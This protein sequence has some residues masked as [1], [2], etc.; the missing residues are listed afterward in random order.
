[1]RAASPLPINIKI[2]NMTSCSH[3][4]AVTSIYR[5]DLVPLGRF[6]LAREDVEMRDAAGWTLLH[7]AA[8]CGNAPACRAL[9]GAGASIDAISD[10]GRTALHLVM[11][12]EIAALEVLLDGGANIN[13]VD[14][15]G[16]TPLYDAIRWCDD[17]VVL[18]LINRGADIHRQFPGTGS[19]LHFA[20]EN[21]MPSVCIELLDR[22]IDATLENKDGRTAMDLAIA[23]QKQECIDVMRVWHS[24]NTARR[25]LAEIKMAAI[26]CSADQ[27]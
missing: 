7:A 16:K 26:K 4:D 18:L 27:P 23:T 8:S 20:A 13:A 2:S 5:N 3:D 11:G 10:G 6:L 1:M 22:G 17:P 12:S 14:R 19:L 21:D 24:A 25:A 9:I 15:N